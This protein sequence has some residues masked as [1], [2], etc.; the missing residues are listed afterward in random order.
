MSEI[1][2]EALGRCQH[3][4]QVVLDLRRKRDQAF[5]SIKHCYVSPT[6]DS[7]MVVHHFD[8]GVIRTACDKIEEANIELMTAVDE[9]N[10]WAKEA[11]Q[12]LIKIIKLAR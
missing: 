6:H 9:Y 10:K 1:N 3:L 8:P 5:N 4:K 2:F 11:E 12:P 7:A